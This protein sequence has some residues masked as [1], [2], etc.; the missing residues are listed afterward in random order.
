MSTLLLL[1]AVGLRDREGEALARSCGDDLRAVWDHWS[2]GCT[3]AWLLVEV[4][5]PFDRVVDVI[6]EAA[7]GYPRAEL[8]ARVDSAR[9]GASPAAAWRIARSLGRELDVPS[10]ALAGALREG[11]A[12]EEF[13]DALEGRLGRCS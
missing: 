7:R 12:F 2:D 11:F 4:G 3:L 1:R 10:D 6:G 8:H 9:D 5:L 13:L